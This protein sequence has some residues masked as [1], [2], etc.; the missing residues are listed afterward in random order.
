MAALAPPKRLEDW[1]AKPDGTGSLGWN[2][3]PLPIPR[4]AFALLLRKAGAGAFLWEGLPCSS[5]QACGEAARKHRW[6]KYSCALIYYCGAC[7]RKTP[8]LRTVRALSTP[9]PAQLPPDLL[10]A[11]CP[12]MPSQS[13]ILMPRSGPEPRRRTSGV[14]VCVGGSFQQRCSGDAPLSLGA[15]A[16][17]PQ[18]PGGLS[19][20]MASP[21]SCGQDG[22]R[23]AS[24]GS[25]RDCCPDGLG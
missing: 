13:G 3:R 16:I 7:P 4:E 18:P 12:G 11:T 17:C 2:R 6:G 15:G 1:D 25:A 24:F 22:P 8:P 10:S 20:G 23:R 19:L 5:D 9:P 21:V 14:S